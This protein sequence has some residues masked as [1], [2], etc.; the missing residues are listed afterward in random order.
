MPVLI[1]IAKT[2][3]ILLSLV[4]TA[5]FLRAI[6]SFIPAWQETRF[7]AFLITLT[8]PVILPVRF[9][10]QKFNIGQDLPID[11]SFTITYFL[12]IFIEALLPV[13]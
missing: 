7:N 9:L 8:E 6:V 1:V 2:I 5:M 12:L 3:S 4:S 11:L 10:M 13:I